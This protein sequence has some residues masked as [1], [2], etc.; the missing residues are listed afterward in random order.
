L[1]YC[2]DLTKDLSPENYFEQ[3]IAGMNH[4]GWILGHLTFVAQFGVT[5][6]EGEGWL[7][8]V[9]NEKFGVGSK[10]SNDASQYPSSQE[11]FASYEDGHARLTHAAQSLNKTFLDKPTEIEAL[12]PMFPTQGL[13]LAHILTSHEATHLGQLSAWRRAMALDSIRF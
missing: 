8:E 2:R 3:P 4:P 7:D 1:D 13:L 11:L 5:L 12:R 9:W 6:C 10:P